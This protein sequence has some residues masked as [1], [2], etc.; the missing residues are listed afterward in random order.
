M[1][2]EDEYGLVWETHLSW[3]IIIFSLFSLT[4]NINNFFLIKNELFSIFSKFCLA[5]VLKQVDL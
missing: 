3:I 5:K 4:E 1:E 2:L